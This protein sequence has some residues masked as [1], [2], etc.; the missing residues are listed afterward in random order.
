[1]K[2]K[3]SVFIA[4]IA[5]VLLG[6]TNTAAQGTNAY[7]KKGGATV[8]QSAIS[9]IDS[10]VFKPYANSEDKTISIDGVVSVY[11]PKH[12][13]STDE[14]KVQ[15]LEDSDI[16]DVFEITSPLYQVKKQSD[17]QIKIDLGRNEPLY[18]NPIEVVVNIPSNFT[19]NDL[20]D[21][22]QLFALIY[23]QA[24]DEV[25][26]HFEVIPA[27][28]NLANR[29][30]TA[31][32]PYWIFTNE[33]NGNY[34]TYLAVASLEN[35]NSLRSST[36]SPY[37]SETCLIGNAICPTSTCEV[38]SPFNMNRLLKNEKEA[39]PH[40]GTDFRAPVG[41]S[42]SA[43]A[44]GTINY[45]GT[46]KD[47]HGNVTGWGLYILVEHQNPHSVSLYAHLS[48]TT[49]KVGDTVKQGQEIAKS[50]NSGTGTGA[51]LHLEV[52]HLISKQWLT[53][54]HA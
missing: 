33:R 16:Q 5:L 44:A 35:E 40:Y 6:T 3:I 25:I 29:T 20:S 54:S 19:A 43:I 39:R 17:Y 4:A 26:D 27:E 45:I 2:T 15:E 11:F 9:N 48:E 24:E 1:M 22:I 49:V 14:P 12:S 18:E 13:I 21:D 32:L 10:I 7:F 47:K 37:V 41:T 34:E 8:F 28:V 53:K 50:G 52:D 42:V 46:Q 38:T 36:A 23:Q 30:I 31:I 51:H